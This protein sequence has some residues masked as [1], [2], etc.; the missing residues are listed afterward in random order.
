VAFGVVD[1]PAALAS[2]VTIQSLQG[3]PQPSLRCG[4]ISAS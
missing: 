4:R 3:G 1:W 2:E